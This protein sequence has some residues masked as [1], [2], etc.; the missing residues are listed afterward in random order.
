MFKCSTKSLEGSQ[1][2]YSGGTEWIDALQACLIGSNI[3][4]SMLCTGF[5][6]EKSKQ[7]LTQSVGYNHPMLFFPP[8]ISSSGAS[9]TMVVSVRSF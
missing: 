5:G 4:Q 1:A 7:A 6:Q 3:K 2:T 9:R 8:S